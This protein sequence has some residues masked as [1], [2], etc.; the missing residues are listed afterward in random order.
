MAISTAGRA[1][2]ALLL[3]VSAFSNAR[4]FQWNHPAG[5]FYS[6]APLPATS[7]ASSCSTSLLDDVKR[8]TAAIALSTT[9]AL[10]T[11]SSLPLPA[12]AAAAAAAADTTSIS[13][14]TIQVELNAPIL[15]KRLKSEKYQRELLDALRETQDVI[16]G[17]AIKVTP[18]SNIGGAIRDLLSGRGE[19]TVNGQPVDVALLESERGEITVRIRNPLLPKV[20][21][22]SSSARI[23]FLSSDE[24]TVERAPVRNV[25]RPDLGTLLR[26]AWLVLGPSS[27]GV[28]GADDEINFMA[29]LGRAYG[30]DMTTPF[31]DQ[32]FWG[33]AISVPVPRAEDKGG[34]Y[35][36][37]ANNRDVAGSVSLGLGAVY[38]GA[39]A[40]HTAQIEEE[41]ARAKE[42]KEA[43]EAKAKAKPE[44]VAEIKN[45]KADKAEMD[46]PPKAK[47]KQLLRIEDGEV[48]EKK[49]K[50]SRLRRFFSSS[51]S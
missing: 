1:A 33:G 7:V 30:W 14:K 49:K 35:T 50:K 6:A 15:I 41:E 39:Y 40:Y 21:I 43:S 34:P 27:D 32:K 47:T 3:V 8:A 48:V 19:I 28:G 36:Y 22:L 42:K 11:I 31:W 17:D 12:K 20:P 5:T 26:A 16:G 29:L 46:K 18:P 38:G 13:S 45:E 24:K 9:L 51:R 10:G 37:V 4:A 25:E 23:P 44:P 2:V